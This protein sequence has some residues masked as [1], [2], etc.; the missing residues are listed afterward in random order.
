MHL[1]HLPTRQPGLRTPV[2]LSVTAGQLPGA[3][4][5]EPSMQLGSLSLSWLC[6]ALHYEQVLCWSVVVGKQGDVTENP[7]SKT[8]CCPQVKHVGDYHSVLCSMLPL[9]LL[10]GSG[11][12]G[13]CPEEC[14]APLS[15]STK[16]LCCS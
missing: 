5:A 4:S 8:A 11:D 15:R 16:L 7:D 2:L 1:E 10:L 13:R 14:V 6:G 12:S 3:A 9:C